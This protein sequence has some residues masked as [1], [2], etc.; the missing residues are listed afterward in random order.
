LC[1]PAGLDKGSVIA[2]EIITVRRPSHLEI[3]DLLEK[4]GHLI[5]RAHQVSVAMFEARSGAYNITAPQHVVMTALFKHAHV[6]QV[7]LAAMIGLDKVTTG[8]I[9]S[10]L[11]KRGLIVRR[12]SPSDGRAHELML[13][14]AGTRM[15]MEMQHLVKDYHEELLGNLTKA[16]R[17]KLVKLLRR[18]IGV[19]PPQRAAETKAG[20]K[21]KK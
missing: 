13:S 19:E 20:S 8:N 21:R 5:R 6:D 7:S 14:E 4:P 12:R 18:M 9:V 17:A 11:Q 15:L 10:R 3:A 16:E 2:T 1:L